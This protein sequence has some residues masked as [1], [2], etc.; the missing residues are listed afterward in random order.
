MKDERPSQDEINVWLDTAAP[1]LRFFSSN[2]DTGKWCIFRSAEEIDEAWATVKALA[3]AEKILCAK[4]STA[5]GRRYHEG[6]VICI[7]TADWNDQ[8]DLMTVRGVLRDAGFTEE[9]GYKRDCD[10]IKRVYGAE[11]WYVRA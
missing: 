6:H 8:A 2:F 11:E 4:V 10:T 9:L 5:I 1:S 7:Y 3:A